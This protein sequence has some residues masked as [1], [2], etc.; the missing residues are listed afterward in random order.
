MDEAYSYG[1]ISVTFFAEEDRISQVERK[2]IVYRG[3]LSHCIG[4]ASL[5]KNVLTSESIKRMEFEGK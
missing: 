3:P 2:G 4:L 5:A 1:I